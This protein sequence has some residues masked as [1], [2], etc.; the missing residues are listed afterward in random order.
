MD[1]GVLFNVLDLNE[2]ARELR[3]SHDN[4]DKARKSE[5]DEVQGV[6]RVVEKSKQ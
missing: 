2:G 1:L 5:N 3:L 4:R 6:Q